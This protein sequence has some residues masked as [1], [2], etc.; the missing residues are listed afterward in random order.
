MCTANG[1]AYHAFL[2]PLI[3]INISVLYIFYLLYMKLDKKAMNY[4]IILLVALEHT[5]C[6][7]IGNKFSDKVFFSFEQGSFFFF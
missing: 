6:P 1:V 3:S 7:S 2:P 4:G 5:P